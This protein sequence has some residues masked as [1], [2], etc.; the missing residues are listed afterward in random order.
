MYNNIFIS[1]YKYFRRKKSNVAKFQAIAF[2]LIFQLLTL[3]IPTFLIRITLFGNMDTSVRIPKM[4]ALPFIIIWAGILFFY[5][6]NEKIA[7]LSNSYQTKSESF[8]KAW[9]RFPTFFLIFFVI[10]I[11]VIAINTKKVDR[12]YKMLP[13]NRNS[14]LW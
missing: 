3:A 11:F 14:S 6:N 9:L 7:E 2:V 8:K 12:K 5:Y 4:M 13:S 1:F 10:I